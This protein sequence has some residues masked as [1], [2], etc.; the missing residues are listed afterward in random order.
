VAPAIERS[1]ELTSRRE[2]SCAQWQDPPTG[3]A[4]QIVGQRVPARSMGAVSRWRRFR[5]VLGN[6][7]MATDWQH[8][9][10]KQPILANSVPPSKPALTCG[11][12]DFQLLLIALWWLSGGGSAGS[13]PAGGA[14]LRGL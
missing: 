8:E 6:A 2:R 3:V 10:R 1:D 9:V 4:R 7:A 13:N 14:Q 12:V 5:P 11:F